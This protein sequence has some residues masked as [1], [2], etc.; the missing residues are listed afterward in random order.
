MIQNTLKQLTDNLNYLS[1]TLSSKENILHFLETENSE[2]F[3]RIAKMDYSILILSQELESIS[4]QIDRNL[5]TSNYNSFFD[6]VDTPSQGIATLTVGSKGEGALLPVGV[7]STSELISLDDT[8][9]S[10]TQ[11]DS[12]ITVNSGD[13]QFEELRQWKALKSNVLD[14]SAVTGTGT[15]VFLSGTQLDNQLYLIHIGEDTSVP[16]AIIV[17]TTIDQARC[18]FYVYGGESEVSDP[19]GKYIRAFDGGSINSFPSWNYDVGR[20]T[21]GLYS[22]LVIRYDTNLN[23]YVT[24]SQYTTPS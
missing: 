22:S 10:Y 19:N 13:V 8:P 4:K 3:G 11:R 1:K 16:I 9:S 18:A 5:V 23:G 24:E 17:G 2:L 20:A 7:L 21:L 12:V 14:L 6:F 15:N